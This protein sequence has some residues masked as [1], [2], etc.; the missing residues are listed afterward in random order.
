MRIQHRRLLAVAA[1]ATLV[2]GVAL[3]SAPAAFAAPAAPGPTAP[4]PQGQASPVTVTVSGFPT[5]VKAGNAVEFTA[6]FKNTAD[7][8]MDAT[9]SFSVASTSSALKQSQLKLEF[10][11]PGG[12]QWQE[13]KPFGLTSGGAWEL[14]GS[15]AQL[16]LAPGAE[17][18]Y[19]LRL[20]FSAD[21]APGQASAAVSAAV[22][23]P[24]VPAG[25][26]SSSLA[27]GGTPN[28]TVEPPDGPATPPTA[29]L[30]EIKVEGLP[31]TFTAGGEAKAFK[32]VYTNRTG[33]DLRIVPAIVFQGEGV[34]RPDAVKLEFQT[35]DGKWLAATPT[36]D[37]DIPGTQLGV[38]LATG[39]KADDVIPLP[40]GETRTVNLRLAFTKDAP[41]A[42][43][44]V[45]ANAY[46]LPG[47][48]EHQAGTSSPKAPFKIEAAATGGATTPATPAPT[49]PATPS[50]T[51]PAPAT[52]APVVPAAQSG[53]GAQGSSATGSSGTTATAASAT[54]TD[55]ASTGGGSSAAPMA[56][57]GA[58]AIALGAGTLVV[59]RRRMAAAQ[60]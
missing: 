23:D 34:L 39:N 49:T 25:Q 7:H 32:A 19:R 22:T 38:A 47:Q 44:T 5:T 12:T 1:A 9:T 52:Q 37:G 8:Q 20:T 56:I 24:T 10:Q 36:P 40:K 30:P 15:A 48:G 35:Q 42:A 60:R 55:L 14:D 16:H 6:T 21:A 17:A 28:F 54:G 33:K 29:G 41:V 53:T 58:T 46:S 51:D 43:E 27:S 13:A 57:T 18:V 59:A 26:P 4:A 45:F 2:S 3:T 31:E 50:T 11:R